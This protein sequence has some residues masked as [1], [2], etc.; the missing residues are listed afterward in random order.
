MRVASAFAFS[1]FSLSEGAII[2]VSQSKNIR[3]GYPYSTSNG[4]I[5]L[6]ESYNS[7]S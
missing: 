6:R 5:W 4:F 2:G 7:M 1:T 3:A